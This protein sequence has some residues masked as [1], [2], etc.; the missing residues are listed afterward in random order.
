L[1]EQATV[2]HKRAKGTIGEAQRSR[3]RDVITNPPN[4]AV[5]VKRDGLAADQTQEVN[6]VNRVHEQP[7]IADERS[8]AALHA[9]AFSRVRCNN[10]DSMKRPDLKA[11]S[12][13]LANTGV[14][15]SVHRSQGDQSALRGQGCKTSHLATGQ[16]YR[17]FRKQMQSGSKH[18][19]SHRFVV[20]M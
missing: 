8:L 16:S 17:F 2:H 9:P 4:R 13:G 18:L 7:P 6:C 19:T 20:F 15:P 12:E 3:N 14:E 11:R 1:T 10:Y 5:S